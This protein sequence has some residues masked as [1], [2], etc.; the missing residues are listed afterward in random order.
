MAGLG[1]GGIGLIV[2]E[3]GEAGVEELGE[4]E[5]AGLGGGAALTALAAGELDEGALDGG[6]EGEGSREP[7][8]L[9]RVAAVFEGVKVALGGAGAGPF[10]APSTALRA[11]SRHFGPPCVCLSTDRKRINGWGRGKRRPY[12]T[13]IGRAFG[14]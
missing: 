2:L 11:G 8:D 10:A 3:A 7:A 6:Q 13:M 5:M 12:A 4:E 14:W 1:D 9:G